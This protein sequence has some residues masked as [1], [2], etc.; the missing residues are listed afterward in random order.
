VTL[1]IFLLPRRL[2]I[3]PTNRATMMYLQPT[4]VKAI[5]MEDVAAGH[6]LA[7]LSWIEWLQT[8]GALF[9]IPRRLSFIPY[10]GRWA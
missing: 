6:D 5:G 1:I 2:E 4:I 8:Y 10:I 9:R 3:V 7:N